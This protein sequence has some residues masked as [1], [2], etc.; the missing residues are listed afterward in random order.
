MKTAALLTT[1]LLL[2]ACA[3]LPAP[4]PPQPAEP[5]KPS[6]PY[7]SLDMQAQIDSLG[8]QVA[9]LENQLESLHTRIQQLERQSSAPRAAAAAPRRPP[10]ARRCRC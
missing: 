1:A 2:S 6:V 3:T 7:P 8:I 9:R 10:V 5:A 4:V